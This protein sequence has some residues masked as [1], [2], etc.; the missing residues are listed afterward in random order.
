MID[1]E[2]ALA[3]LGTGIGPTEVSVTL[4]CD[5]SYISQLLMDEDFRGRVLAK[6]MEHLQAATKRD[7]VINS[8]ED[9]LLLKLK[10]SMC[11][12][13]KTQDILRAFAILNNA[14]RRGAS[15]VAPVNIQQ[16]VVQLQLPPAARRI[17][18]TNHS[19]EVV[20]VDNKSTLT[21]PLQTL[22]KDRIKKAAN[23]HS[24]TPALASPAGETSVG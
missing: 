23:G 18:T 2:R 24:E 9:D 3:L 10:D 4:G 16:T 22:L 5:P 19:G 21:M 1:K 7:E 8:I 14:K 13:V 11:F 12:L 20:Q 17:F 15:S 6:R